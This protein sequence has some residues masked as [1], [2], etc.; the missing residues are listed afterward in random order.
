L[1]STL[2][3]PPIEGLP[4]QLADIL[5]LI[6]GHQIVEIEIAGSGVS[7]AATAAPPA[8]EFTVPPTTPPPPPTQAPPPRP[9]ATNAP[10]TNAPTT[11]APTTTEAAAPAPA[12]VAQVSTNSLGAGVGA[13]LVL[14]LLAQ[15]RLGLLIR[16]W[17][18]GILAPVA[19]A[20]DPCSLEV[21]DA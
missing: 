1:V 9:V 8:P 18:Q 10:V 2:D 16:R 19:A 21:P 20:G 14:A 12:P 7:L 15:P 6:R 11:A 17:T 13:A 4:L 3:L 5:E